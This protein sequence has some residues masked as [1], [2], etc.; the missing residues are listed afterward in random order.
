MLLSLPGPL[1]QGPECAG[2]NHRVAQRASGSLADQLTGV[3]HALQLRMNRLARGAGC[4]DH[5][6][7]GNAAPFGQQVVDYRADAGRSRHQGSLSEGL[8]DRR[9]RG[10]HSLPGMKRKVRPSILLLDG[11]SVN[12]P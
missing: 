8:A 3:H 9:E 2:G 1:T 5:V 10:G 6:A 12:Y 11:L 4:G 7:I